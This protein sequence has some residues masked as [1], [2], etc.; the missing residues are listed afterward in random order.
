M[1]NEDLWFFLGKII[2]KIKN[3]YTKCIRSKANIFFQ[4]FKIDFIAGR[5]RD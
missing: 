1:V 5:E 4:V 3:K 2:I